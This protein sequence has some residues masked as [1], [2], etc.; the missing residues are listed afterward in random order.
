MDSKCK[1]VATS[2][3]AVAMLLGVFRVSHATERVADPA[4]WGVYAKLVGTG[5]K[6]ELGTRA[7]RWGEGEQMIEEDASFGRSVITLGPTPGTLALELG[8][9]GLHTFQGTVA[10]DG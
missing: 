10:S 4:I 8:T 6:G 3:L 2:L 1:S 7:T 5:W 9:T